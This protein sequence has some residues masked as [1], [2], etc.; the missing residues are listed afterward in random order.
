[1][2][3]NRPSLP[4]LGSPQAVAGIA[5]VLVVPMAIGT[6]V[7]L[8]EIMIHMCDVINTIVINRQL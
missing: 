8:C 5:P 1:M 6:G 2:P 4:L 3:Y 7:F